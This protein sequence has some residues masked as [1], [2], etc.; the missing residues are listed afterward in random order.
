MRRLAGLHSLA[1]GC[2]VCRPAPGPGTRGIAV[3]LLRA[4]GKQLRLRDTPHD[5]RRQLE[6]AAIWLAAENI[7][8]LIVV[9][10]DRLAPAAWTMLL[11]LAGRVPYLTLS[12]VIHRPDVPDRLRAVL[13]DQP[14]DELHYQELDPSPAAPDAA[15]RRDR[16]SAFP[17]VP[18]TDFPLFVSACQ[19]M[20]NPKD[21]ARVLAAHAAEHA[22]TRAWLHHQRRPAR[23][24]IARRLG[25]LVGGCGDLNETLARLRGAQ[26]ALF[27]AGLARHRSTRST[28]R[29]RTRPRTARR[30]TAPRSTCCAATPAPSAPRSA[31]SRSPAAHRPKRSPAW[32]SPT[33]IPAPQASGSPANARRCPQQ[34]PHSCA[35]AA[36][37]AR[38]NGA[39]P[40]R[41]LF[42]DRHA[43]DRPLNAVG[44]RRRL[45]ELARDTGLTFAPRDVDADDAVHRPRPRGRAMALLNRRL[46]ADRR[47]ALGLSRYELAQASG[48]ATGTLEHIENHGTHDNLQLDS[49]VKLAAALGIDIADLLLREHPGPAAIRG[50]VAV[51]ALLAEQRRPIPAE[52]LAATLGWTLRAHAR[53][54][55]RARPPPL[56]DRTSAPTPSRR[57]DTRSSPHA[58][59]VSDSQRRDAA[60]RQLAPST[61][62]PRA[63]CTASSA[64]HVRTADGTPTPTTTADASRNSSASDSSTTPAANSRSAPS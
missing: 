52:D 47:A 42:T 30:S 60:R 48:L 1:G 51:E 53:R 37:S 40:D 17:D 26:S 13:V 24:M 31:R 57:T 16:G 29:Q 8:D 5:P 14:R 20:L 56:R 38:R 36:S 59:A 15:C 25:A 19:Q 43:P 32:P 6:H 3:A 11:D 41:P 27:L 22:D 62:T 18:D 39:A 12:L 49:A 35:R 63:C 44:V 7:T 9:R 55:A 45:R 2:V 33:S 50:D 64:G 23:A 4:L 34:P 61:S 28:S 58:T 21:A 54:A 46:I 10:A